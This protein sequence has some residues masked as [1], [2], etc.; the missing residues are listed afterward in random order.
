MPDLLINNA[1]PVDSLSWTEQ[2]QISCSVDVDGVGTV[3]ED[4]NK[5][6]S[7]T[8]LNLGISGRGASRTVSLGLW[9]SDLSL[10]ANTADF[11]VS[12]SSSARLTGVQPLV[13]PLLVNTTTTASLNVGAWVID[14]QAVYYQRGV[15]GVGVNSIIYDSEANTSISDF[16]NSGTLNADN[17][18]I[19]SLEYATIPSQVGSVTATGGNTNV[20]L[21]WPTPASDGGSPITSYTIQRATNSTFT[22]GVVTTTG[23]T[24]NST[25]ITGLTNGT[26]YYFKVAAVNAVATAAGTTGVYSDS[27]FVN[28][29]ATPTSP[30]RPGAPTNLIV[31]SGS[32]IPS[33][34]GLDRTT[35]LLL[36]WTA[37]N[38]NG[39]ALTSY[40]IILQPQDGGEA[41]TKSVSGSAT[42]TLFTGLVTNMNYE[43]AMYANNS[44]AGI[45]AFS[46]TIYGK[47]VIESLSKGIIKRYDAS[48]ETWIVVI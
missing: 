32:D 21:R 41:I 18:L 15:T 38:N 13:S 19:G 45:G 29:R 47:P 11:S 14:S 8:G 34:P 27:S 35:S 9:E 22:A 1:T 12:A 37:A 28:S 20:S 3:A 2:R 10:A 6:I 36:Q 39:S 25:V 44:V 4:G 7:V 17:T 48:K 31:L 43:I 24:G 5:Y 16:T 40:F 46:D 42:S 26:L 23:V 30:A 33:A